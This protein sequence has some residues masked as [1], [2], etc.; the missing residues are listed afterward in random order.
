MIVIL[1]EL[2]LILVS[3]HHRFN[4]CSKLSIVEGGR[5]GGRD[6]LVQEN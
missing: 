4:V 3:L 6:N 5:E 2:I 1:F